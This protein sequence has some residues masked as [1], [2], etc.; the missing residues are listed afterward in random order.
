[1]WHA[2]K[3]VPHPKDEKLAWLQIGFR[4]DRPIGDALRLS[5]RHKLLG[6]DQFEVRLPSGKLI[7]QVRS[8][9]GWSSVDLDLNLMKLFRKGDTLNGLQFTL[10]ANATLWIDDLLLYE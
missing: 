7:T 8:G 9:G 1:F 10:P 6:A 2:A 3:S 4:G 5:F